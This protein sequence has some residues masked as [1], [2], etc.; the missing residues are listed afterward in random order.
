MN[1][2]DKTKD[3]GIDKHALTEGNVYR[4]IE[5]RELYLCVSRNIAKYV[6]HLKSGNLFTV[7]EIYTFANF[8]KV[9]HELHITE[10]S[11]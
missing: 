1:I 7:D 10:G 9:H 4:D 5:T 2:I 3:I 11:N 8:T 6:V